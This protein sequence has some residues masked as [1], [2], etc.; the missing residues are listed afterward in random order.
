MDRRKFLKASVLEA[1][2]LAVAPAML[3]QEVRAGVIV[4]GEVYTDGKRGN[5]SADVEK[6]LK[7]T[8]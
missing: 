1:A 5:V 8:G 3:A 4:P 6:H 2:G 7:V